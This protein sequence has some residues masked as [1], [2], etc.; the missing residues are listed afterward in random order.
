MTDPRGRPFAN[1]CFVCGP[2]NP[3]GLRIEFRMDGEICR[4]SFTPGPDHIGYAEQIHGGIVYAALDDVMANWLYLRGERGHTAKCEVRYRQP[5]VLGTRLHLEG[6]LM[7][8]KGALAIMTGKAIREPDGVTV[9]DAQGSF[10]VVGEF[11]GQ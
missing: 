11:D 3:V 7:K 5:V 6:R 2:T 1:N 10:M 4:A 9:A 8:R